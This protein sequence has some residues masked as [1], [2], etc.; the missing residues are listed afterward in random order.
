MIK[1]SRTY[2]EGLHSR[3]RSSGRRLVRSPLRA[4]PT[5]LSL[6]LSLA[7]ANG[8][9]PSLV[10]ADY[11]RAADLVALSAN[12]V[13]WLFPP[14]TKAEHMANLIAIRDLAADDP[15]NPGTRV[16]I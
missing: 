6:M 15:K 3:A 5:G 14:P 1:L 12:D 4:G 13:S 10:G 2:L 7:A 8:F 16:P 9:V 11:A